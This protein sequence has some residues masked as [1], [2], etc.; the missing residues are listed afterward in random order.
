MISNSSTLHIIDNSGVR[1]IKIIK[2]Y[3]KTP[4]SHI[5]VGNLFI[6]SIQDIKIRKK[7]KI[8]KLN[9]G[10]L[11]KSILVRVKKPIVRVDGSTINFFENSAVLVDN[12]K[13][14]LATRIIGFL[15]IDLKKTKRLKVLLLSDGAF[16]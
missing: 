13:K 12:K 3:K 14:P 10:D 9:N 6:G 7:S 4:F 2:F 5:T 8:K 1:Y 16:L 15:P 11:K